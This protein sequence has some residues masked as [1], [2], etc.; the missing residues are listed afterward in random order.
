M[1]A[2]DPDLHPLSAIIAQRGIKTS[3]DFAEFMGALMGDLVEGLIEPQVAHAA[4][5]AAE[6][7]LKIAKL[8]MQYGEIPDGETPRI[9]QL[10]GKSKKEK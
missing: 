2:L 5:V 4:C 8:Q 1:T 10:T 9:L 3:A 7:L 6:Q